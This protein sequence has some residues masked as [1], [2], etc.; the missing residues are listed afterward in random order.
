M[1][2]QTP[3]IVKL[4]LQPVKY[5]TLL[6]LIMYYLYVDIYMLGTTIHLLS[7]IHLNMLVLI[8]VSEE[9]LANLLI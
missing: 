1:K 4:P 8:K 6:L 7:S 3:S 5:L 2:C 9:T